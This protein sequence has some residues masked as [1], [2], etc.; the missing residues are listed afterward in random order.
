MTNLMNFKVF[1]LIY[2]Q[3]LPSALFKIDIT[4]PLLTTK[5]LHGKGNFMLLTWPMRAGIFSLMV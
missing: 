4:I 5:S 1:G 3:V 2:S